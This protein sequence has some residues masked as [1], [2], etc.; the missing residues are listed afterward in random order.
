MRGRNVKVH[1][2]EYFTENLGA[3][4]GDILEVFSILTKFRKTSF[5]PL[6]V[7]QSFIDEVKA[8]EYDYRN[9]QERLKML[10]EEQEIRKHDQ[11][12]KEKK[13][14][15]NELCDGKCNCKLHRIK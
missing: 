12:Q 11:E 13:E 10:F 6:K 15:L 1:K 4:E 8:I 14:K 3:L 5:K 2:E 7:E 9:I